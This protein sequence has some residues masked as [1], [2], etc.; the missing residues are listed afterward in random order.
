MFP[1][2]QQDWIARFAKHCGAE[3]Y[4]DEN[5]L[6]IEVTARGVSIVAAIQ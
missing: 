1:G 2:D 6:P 4:V 3:I 5:T